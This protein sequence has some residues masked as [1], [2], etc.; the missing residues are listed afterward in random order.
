M[1]QL[2]PGN[3]LRYAGDVNIE[4]VDIITPKGTYINVKNQLIQLRIFEDIFSEQS[5]IFRL[6]IPCLC[7]SVV[8]N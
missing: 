7:E 8:E 5:Y 4:K 2:N 1:P 3:Q 6:K